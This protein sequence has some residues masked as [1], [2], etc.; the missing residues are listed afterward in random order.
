MTDG[1]PKRY[2]ELDVL[3]GL[4]AVAVLLFHYTTRY[5]ELYGHPG[6]MPLTF[7]N[8]ICGVYLFFIISGFV[9]FMTLERT[10]APL[11]FLVSRASRLYPVY[12]VSVI[13]TYAVVSL[14]G[15]PGMEV[16]FR[17]AFLN[18]SMCH[19]WAGIPSV[20]GVYWT[21]GVELK[22]YLLMFALFSLRTL[23]RTELV[24]GI[25]L[26]LALGIPWLKGLLPPIV[27][28]GLFAMLLPEYANLFAAGILFYRLKTVG[29]SPTRHF[30]IA[31]CAAGHLAVR[32]AEHFALAS[33]AFVLFYLFVG[34]R[35]AF[36]S[37]RP[38]VF[39][40]AI[41][42]PLYLTHENIGFVILRGLYYL[43]SSSLLAV[44]IAA[45]AALSLASLLTF[46]VEQ[47]SMRAIRTAYKRLQARRSAVSTL[48]SPQLR[49]AE[50]TECRGA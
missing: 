34:G 24:M 32:G 41:S 13:L 22:F 30:L 2:L 5:Q 45:V 3:R 50:G 28:K 19:G 10:K 37:W 44:S 35:L 18:L 27:Y 6:G 33:P 26:A 4:A 17:D 46:F 11:D 23:R 49:P 39:L 7:P 47:P 29:S 31:A 25:W 14:F 43:S 20:D 21:L 1:M 48:S 8:G 15:L 16:S 40:G 38:L 9:I 42:Y 12:W 36:L